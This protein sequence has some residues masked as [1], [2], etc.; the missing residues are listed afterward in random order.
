MNC[1][2]RFVSF[3]YFSSLMVPDL[4]PGQFSHQ[5]VQVEIP[6]IRRRLPTPRLPDVA[7]SW[8]RYRWCKRKGA[9]TVL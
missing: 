5:T 9:A 3:G 4:V 1:E 7:S 2:F 6:P 8:S